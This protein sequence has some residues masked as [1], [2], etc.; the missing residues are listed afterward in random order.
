MGNNDE[1]VASDP[2]DGG[3]QSEPSVE[4][5]D[6][7]NDGSEAS[8]DVVDAGAGAGVSTSRC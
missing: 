2:A 8:A 1:D 5:D 4:D 6:D 3:N 7:W